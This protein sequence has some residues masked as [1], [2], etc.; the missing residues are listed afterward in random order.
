M[1]APEPLRWDILFGKLVVEQGL[2]SAAQVQECLSTLLKLSDE[3]VT[4]LPKLAD[5]LVRKGYLSARQYEATLHAS[6][7]PS[8][9]A[10]ASAREAP[11]PGEAAEAAKDPANVFGKYVRARRL[12]A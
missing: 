11:L 12:G 10:G 3:G 9:G 4:P 2:A 1:G 5:L 6:Q 7:H 8:S